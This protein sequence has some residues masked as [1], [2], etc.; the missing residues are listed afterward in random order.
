L[1]V[2]VIWSH[3]GRFSDVCWYTALHRDQSEIR[4][5]RRRARTSRKCVIL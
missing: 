1:S 5:S 4:P 3:L 2:T